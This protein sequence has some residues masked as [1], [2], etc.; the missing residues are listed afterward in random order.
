MSKLQIVTMDKKAQKDISLFLETFLHCF[1]LH[2]GVKVQMPRLC[3]VKLKTVK[4]QKQ[5]HSKQSRNSSRWCLKMC[6]PSF[7]KLFFILAQP[8]FSL[9]PIC[10]QHST[11]GPREVLN[12][13]L[14]QLVC[15]NAKSMKEELHLPRTLQSMPS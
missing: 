6:S 10:K 1:Q 8:I 12:L 15:K 14:R 4:F 5:Q 9:L 7:Q 13:Q 3:R 2:I 11:L